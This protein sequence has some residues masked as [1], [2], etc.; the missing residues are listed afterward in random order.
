M[1]SEKI[2][3]KIMR[4]ML[5]VCVEFNDVESNPPLLFYESLPS[6]S[7]TFTRIGELE[8]GLL[9]GLGVYG[10]RDG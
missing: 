8:Y 6:I 2:K 7:P 5:E 1:Q 10:N 3:R 4:T 9:D